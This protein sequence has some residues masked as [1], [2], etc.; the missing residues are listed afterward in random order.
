MIFFVTTGMFA[1]TTL[2]PGLFLAFVP[3]LMRKNECFAVTV[4]PS[5]QT[6]PRLVALKKRYTVTMLIV[7]VAFTIVAAVAGALLV[8]RSEQY[9]DTATAAIT[10]AALECLTVLAIVIVSFVLMLRGRR[11]V[12]DIKRTEGWA[13]QRKE[14]AVALAEENLPGPL[15]VSWNL[16]HVPLI[17][18]TLALGLALYPSM[19]DMLPIHADLAGNVDSWEPKTLTN[20]IGLPILCELF[21]AAIFTFVH[22]MMSHSKRLL[23]PA[24]PAASALAYGLFA[25]AQSIFMLVVGLLVSS[26]VGISILFCFAGIATM[27]QAVVV[28][29]ALCLLILF[30][31]IAMSVVY[32]QAGS[33]VFKRMQNEDFLLADEDSHWKLGVFYF[34]PDDASIFLPKRFGIGWTMNFARPVTWAIT[35][36]GLAATVAFIV[37]VSLLAS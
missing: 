34:N 24:A 17:L 28:L 11:K 26:G 36:G 37:A 2:I 27:G 23:D 16:L 18:G 22:W 5:A 29:V 9:D 6:D 3:Y 35:L 20:A 19:P 30:G 21:M 25:R 13:A 10:G 4:P 14:S 31:S 7:S 32:G 33:R 1:A 15:S 12:Q 8:N